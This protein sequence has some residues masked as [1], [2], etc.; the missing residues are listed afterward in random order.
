MTGTKLAQISEGNNNYD[1]VIEQCKALQF[2]ISYVAN[3]QKSNK[4]QIPQFRT[5]GAG[6]QGHPV[7]VSDAEK[8]TDEFREAHQSN[9]FA[10]YVSD[11]ISLDRAIPDIRHPQ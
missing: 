10:G 2:T 6:E 8:N 11:K 3:I 4:F 7:H 1:C 9:G 5:E